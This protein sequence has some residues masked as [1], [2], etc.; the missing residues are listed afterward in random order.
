MIAYGPA[1]PTAF[2]LRIAARVAASSCKC[3]SSRSIRCRSNGTI[4]LASGPSISSR[5]CRASCSLPARMISN[6]LRYPALPGSSE[7]GQN[8]AELRAGEIHQVQT[9]EAG[10]ANHLRRFRGAGQL[11]QLPVLLVGQRRTAVAVV[12]V[13]GKVRSVVRRVEI[14]PGGNP[15]ELLAARVSLR[16]DR[17]AARRSTGCDA[18]PRRRAATRR[19]GR[20]APP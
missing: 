3:D 12:A 10:V 16:S 14:D 4:G 20:R 2:P 11:H 8:G 19:A 13:D 1:E 18:N 9:A 5:G 6:A 15:L 17:P 7:G